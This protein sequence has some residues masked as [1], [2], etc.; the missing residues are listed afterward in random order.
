MALPQNMIGNASNL[1]TY[2]RWPPSAVQTL[3]AATT[4]AP[5]GNMIAIGAAAAILLTATPTIT[6]GTA[7]QHLTIVNESAFPIGFQDASAI[8]STLRLLGGKMVILRQYHSLNLVYDLTLAAWVQRSAFDYPQGQNFF[9][10]TP[11]N[12]KNTMDDEFDDSANMS[13]TNNGLNARWT[14]RNPSTTTVAYGTQGYLS[15]APPASAT[16]NFRLWTQTKPAAQDYTVETK[17]SL[18]GSMISSALAGLCLDNGTAFYSFGIAFQTGTPFYYLS[19]FR[20][21]NVTTFNSTLLA[22]QFW[23]AT[24]AYL[25]IAYVN[26]TTTINCWASSDGVGWILVA[27]FV[28]A[29][30]HTTVGVLVD[31][32]NN[33]G[34][35]VAY[36]DFFRRSA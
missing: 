17:C 21:T 12:A 24:H 6:A 29:I 26:G 14:A 7:G 1:Y 16:T 27:S 9:R 35:T 19:V 23:T 25:R 3:A 36:Y 20:W 11:P 18:T 2:E 5:S 34:N 15:L 13:G 4:I 32:E 28:D 31:E 33:A 8:A 30:T 22:A 10:D